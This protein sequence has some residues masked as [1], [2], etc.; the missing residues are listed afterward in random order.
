MHFTPYLFPGR[1]PASLLLVVLSVGD[2][3]GDANGVR[4]SAS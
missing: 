3:F 4:G 1:E 2:D